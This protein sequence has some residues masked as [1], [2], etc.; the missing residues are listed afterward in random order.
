MKIKLKG[1]LDSELIALGCKPDDIIHATPDPV[2]KTGAM[3]FTTLKNGDSY[4]CVVWPDNYAIVPV[5]PENNN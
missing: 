3:Y 1:E 5:A 2:G 4:D